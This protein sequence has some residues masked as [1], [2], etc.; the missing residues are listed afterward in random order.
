MRTTV[1]SLVAVCV[2][3]LSALACG[4]AAGGLQP[5]I[6][7]FSLLLGGGAGIWAWW[8]MRYLPPALPVKGWA[9]WAVVVVFTLFALRAFGWVIFFKDNSIAFLSPNNLGDLSLHLTYIHYFANGA[10]LWPANPIF[11]DGALH[12]P[13]GVDFF[14]SLLL[15]SGVDTVRGL[16]WAGLLGSLATA[17][18]LWRWGGAFALAGFLFNG[19]TAGLAF[20][21]T[22]ELADFQDKVAWK[23]IPLALFVTQRGLLYAIPVG[24]ALLWSWR[25]RFL[26]D[27][28]GLPFAVELLLY[29]SMPLFHLHTFLFLSAML[30]AWGGYALIQS[31]RGQFRAIFTLVAA[32]FLPATALIWLLTGGSPG[33][34]GIHWLPG[35]MQ[36]PDH[37][38]AFW[39]TNFGFWPLAV[40]TLIGW[41]IYHAQR[42]EREAEIDLT[43]VFPAVTLFFIGCFVM[44]APW[45]WDNTKLFLWC[46]LAIL[47]PLWRLLTAT[48]FRAIACVL[49]FF[50]GALSLVGGLDGSHDGYP[51]AQRSEL[52]DLQAALALYPDLPVTA[53]FACAPTF[54]HPLLLLG[55]K[56][57]LGYEGHLSSHGIEYGLQ[58][59]HLIALLHGAPGWEEH[60]RA[61]GAQALYWGP[62]EQEQ[63][64]T[65]APTQWRDVAPLLAQGPW[66]ALYDLRPPL[67]RKE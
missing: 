32:A 65:D 64:G 3:V 39:F 40:V 59:E 60:A 7:T 24:L 22:R 26:K 45:E 18:M 19:G 56:V 8:R 62:L 11:A 38:V 6:A 31:D 53:T 21:A 13:I 14:N 4:A 49:L 55:R 36:D 43:I 66:G 30:G 67:A 17:I 57:V 50:S 15:L 58:K 44:F 42:G 63:Y 27:Q 12:Y 52:D 10:P 25:A 16:V 37:P 34:K 28:R 48:R 35:W 1:A 20:F 61:L 23:S 5:W 54:N 29:A 51:L 9:A 41:L 33:G 46:Y 2:A 47:P